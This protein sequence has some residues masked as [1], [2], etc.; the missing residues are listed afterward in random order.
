MKLFLH[1]L[2]LLKKRLIVKFLVLV[3]LM[4]IFFIAGHFVLKK[5]NLLFVVL[6]LEEHFFD[7][8]VFGLNLIQMLDFLFLQVLLELEVLFNQVAELRVLFGALSLPIANI[9][10]ETLIYGI[11]ALLKGRRLLFVG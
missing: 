3:L 11:R 10:L 6:H 8:L 9:F 1:L 7:F 4:G 2:V 5:K